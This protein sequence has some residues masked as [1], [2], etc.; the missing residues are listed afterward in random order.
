M[1]GFSDVKFRVYVLCVL[2]VDVSEVLLFM[3]VDI[4]LWNWL[5]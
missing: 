3:E 5:D 1:I 2:Y 4:A